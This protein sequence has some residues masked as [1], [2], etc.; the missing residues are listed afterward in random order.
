MWVIVHAFL[1]SADFFQLLRKQIQEYH[2]SVKQFGSRSGPTKR[3]VG[4]DLEPNGLQRLSA[5]NT[6]TSRQSFFFEMA[7]CLVSL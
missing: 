5:D 3:F 2:Q 7:S 6:V 4:P 1:S